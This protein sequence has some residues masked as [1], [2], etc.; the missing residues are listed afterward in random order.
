M[1]PSDSATWHI[2]AAPHIA[3]GISH[4]FIFAH[5]TCRDFVVPHA[6]NVMCH[7][8]ASGCATCDLNDA[9]RVLLLMNHVLVSSIATCVH[10]RLHML[11]Y[12]CATYFFPSALC[13]T[14]GT[15]HVSWSLNY[16]LVQPSVYRNTVV[17]LSVSWCWSWVQNQAAIVLFCPH[18]LE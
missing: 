16:M 13:V 7:V 2:S 11:H 18:K 17:S 14:S 6:S 12:C 9:P 4:V 10:H 1:S 8:S 5:T 15:R 3:S